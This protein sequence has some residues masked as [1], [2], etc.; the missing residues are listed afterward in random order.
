MSLPREHRLQRVV[1][2]RHEAGALLS[3]ATHLDLRH[4]LGRA[5]DELAEAR[6]L[7][8]DEA[9]DSRPAALT[10][11]DM[12]LAFAEYRVSAARVALHLYGEHASRVG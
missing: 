7:L 10:I 6:D 3:R 4:F 5:L 12:D 9:V 8:D 2:L 1:S 11:I